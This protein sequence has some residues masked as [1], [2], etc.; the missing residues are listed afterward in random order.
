MPPKNNRILLVEQDQ[1]FGDL[2]LNQVLKPL[3]YQVQL[4]ESVADAI[5]E[6]SDFSPDLVITNLNLP[7]LSGNDL[8]VA[9]TA[10]GIE[11]PVIV[12]AKKG[13]ENNII[14]A[15][16]LGA[17]DYLG[18]PVRETEVVAVVERVLG[19]VQA[20]RQREQLTSELKQTNMELQQRLQELAIT[21]TI[22]N[23]VSSIT[24]LN[25][26]YEKILEG[27]LL[28][29][30][31]DHGW[32]MMRKDRGNNFTVTAHQ[33][34]SVDS[35]AIDQPWD[36]GTYSLEDI[37]EE[38][39]SNEDDHLEGVRISKSGKPTLVTP[40]LSHRV[41][42]GLLVMMRD[43]PRPFSSNEQTL[44]EAISD[45]ASLSVTKIRLIQAVKGRAI[46]KS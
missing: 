4:V 7:G 40:I 20:Q 8:L 41:L 32:I 6:V 44:L 17:A 39:Q 12:L 36:E 26:L 34:T 24:D 21:I 29:T 45:Y 3:G 5:K 23:A 15:F 37:L 46:S 35:T 31:A 28:V 13:M 19:Q 42:I 1:N 33:N 30:G 16:R 43:D 10:Q 18:L 22:G 25:S 27:A 38:T 14:K 2:L 11:T 9:F